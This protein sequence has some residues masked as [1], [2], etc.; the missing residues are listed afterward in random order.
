MTPQQLWD[1]YDAA[2]EELTGRESD[3][4]A[5]RMLLHAVTNLIAAREVT[6]QQI[7]AEL[8]ETGVEPA[9]IEAVAD[10]V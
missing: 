10:L 8:T 5:R 4:R 9:V 7:A 1:E 3:D 2:L 6:A